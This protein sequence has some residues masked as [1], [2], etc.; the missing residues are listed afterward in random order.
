MDANPFLGVILHAIGGL[1]AASFYLPYKKVK[2]WSWETYW[3]TGG[4]FSWLIAPILFGLIVVAWIYDVPL[5][6][7]LRGSPQ[8]A[9]WGAFGFGVLW[10]I[11]G[12]TFGLSMRYLGIA[13]GYAIALGFCAAFGTL[14]PPLFEGKFG[15]LLGNASGL[16]VLGGVLACLVGIAFSGAA[17]M[18]KENEL[19]EEQ[20]KEAVEE[21]NFPKGLVI[22]IICGLL[23]ACMA[24]ALAA[25]DPIGKRAIALGTPA[26]WSGLPTL[27]VIMLG[28]LLTNAIWCFVLLAKNHSFFEFGAAAVDPTTGA[29]PVISPAREVEIADSERGAG[30]PIAQMIEPP[31]PARPSLL[32]NYIFSAMAGLIWYF[33]FFF[34]TMGSSKMGPRLGFSSWTLHMASIIVFS[35][36]W[37]ILLKEWRGTSIKTH[38]LI[39]IGLAVLILSTIVVGY[40][41]YLGISR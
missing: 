41:N 10:G 39:G 2:G 5:Y 13:L 35:T 24:F 26:L 3:I 22:A 18:S 40:G 32:G 19:S 27:I 16:V 20:K 14:V 29:L 33:Q 15:A 17:G 1:A 9:L 31:N 36:I 25:G 4:I 23:S 30:T 37:G 38:V 21:F 8:L 12:L 6:A 7:I 11:G 34:Y 28:G